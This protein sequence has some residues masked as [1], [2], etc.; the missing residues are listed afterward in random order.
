MRR[1]AFLHPNFESIFFSGCYGNWPSHVCSSPVLHRRIFYLFFST[2]TQ[3]IIVTVIQ[4][5]HHPENKLRP[6]NSLYSRFFFFYFCFALWNFES[7][8]K[9]VWTCEGQS[10]CSC[11]LKPNMINWPAT[12]ASS[13]L[14]E[15]LPLTEL[16]SPPPESKRKKPVH[17]YV[18]V[19]LFNGNPT[20]KESGNTPLL[21][22]CLMSQ[23]GLQWVYRGIAFQAF[24][25]CILF[26]DHI[27][28][29]FELSNAQ[30]RTTVQKH[31]LIDWRL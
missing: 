26:Q 27:Y 18:F 22:C 3:E 21:L 13:T 15:L 20:V 24:W 16:F 25:V 6:G 5:E 9:S 7:H 4:H 31:A 17:K 8:H 30:M 2:V 1:L 14:N 29:F 11:I 10:R 19:P 12:V 28:F 23:R